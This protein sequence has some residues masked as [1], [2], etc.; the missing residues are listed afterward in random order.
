MD[1][2]SNFLFFSLLFFLKS[3]FYIKS[4]FLYNTLPLWYAAFIMHVVWGYKLIKKCELENN[5]FKNRK[6]YK[7]L[8]KRP[9]YRGFIQHVFIKYYIIHCICAQYLYYTYSN[10]WNNI[11]YFAIA[12]L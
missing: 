1:N 7:H 10:T 5:L 6:D 3:K 9:I 8:E 4:K 2:F 12:F 11:Y